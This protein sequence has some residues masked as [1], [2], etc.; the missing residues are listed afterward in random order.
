MRTSTIQNSREKTHDCRETKNKTERKIGE[1]IKK[2]TLS[3]LFPA[4][5]AAL[6]FDLY[7]LQKEAIEGLTSTTPS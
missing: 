6:I 4:H 5:W 2:I 1:T 3:D 7:G